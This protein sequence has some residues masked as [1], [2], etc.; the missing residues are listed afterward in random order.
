MPFHSTLLP[1]LA[2]HDGLPE[3]PD[4]DEGLAVDLDDQTAVALKFNV[5]AEEHMGAGERSAWLVGLT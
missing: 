4:G 1:H 3:G 2:V 5:A